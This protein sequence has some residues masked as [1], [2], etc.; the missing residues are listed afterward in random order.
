[1]L[2]FC[3]LATRDASFS[4]FLML[5]EFDRGLARLDPPLSDGPVMSLD[6]LYKSSFDD[7]PLSPSLLDDV[8]RFDDEAFD[9]A[10]SKPAAFDDFGADEVGD[11]DGDGLDD[12]PARGGKVASISLGSST[13]INF[14]AC[15]HLGPSTN[16]L[17][18]MSAAWFSVFSYLKFTS[19]V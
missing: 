1:M 9:D 4:L 12:P 13:L 5:D 17:V 3:T 6:L 14:L 16:A 7:P 8:D 15:S 10:L 19:D 11:F 18:K 2:S